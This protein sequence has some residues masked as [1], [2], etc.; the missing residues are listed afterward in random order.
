MLSGLLSNYATVSAQTLS[1]RATP[2]SGRYMVGGGNS[3]SA[4]VGET[5]NT[6]L[7][8]GFTMLT[9]GQQ[10]AELDLA[11]EAMSPNLCVGSSFAIA[12]KAIGFSNPA[13]TFTAQ[14]SN[15]S[16]SFTSPTAIGSIISAIS[17]SIQVTIPPLTPA[18]TGYFIRI[19]S[20]SPVFSSQPVSVSVN[21]LPAIGVVVSPSATVCPG[22]FVT[23]SGTGANTYTWSKAIVDGQP[24]APFSTATYT[25]TG[26]NGIG[27]SNTATQTVTVNPMPSID[28]AATPSTPVCAGTAVTLTATGASSYI[29]NGGVTNGVAFLPPS[30]ATYTVSGMDANGCSTD[31]TWV[32]IAARGDHSLGIKSDGTLW[33]WG[34]NNYGQLGDG[35]TINSNIPVQVGTATD[36]VGIAAGQLHSLGLKAD[37]TAWAWGINTSGELGTTSTAN[38]NT[39][40]LVSMLAGITAV[41]GGYSHSLFLKSD[42]TVWATGRNLEGQLGD[43]TIVSKRQPIQVSGLSNVAAIS[44]GASHSLFLQNNGTAWACGYNYYGSLG[45]NTNTNRAIPVPVTGISGIKSIAA[46]EYHSLFLGNNGTVWGTGYSFDGELGNGSA[47]NRYNP[48]QIP[49]FDHISAIAAG[50]LHSLFLKT[51]GTVWSTGFNKYGA[52]GLGNDFDRQSPAQVTGLT[53]AVSISGGGYHSHFLQGNGAL[54]SCGRNE[55]GQMGT[56]T[57][58]NSTTY[59]PVVNPLGLSILVT[60]TPSATWYLDADNDGHY[61]SSLQSCTSPG[62]GYNQTATASGDCDDAD[63]TKWQSANLYVDVDDDGYTV[64]PQVLLCFGADIPTG[65]S[66]M[67]LGED[68]DDNNSAITPSQIWY[69]DADNDGYYVSSLQSC[70]SPGAGYNQTATTQGDCDDADNTKWRAILR[71]LDADG[72]GYTVG[73]LTSVCYGATVPAIYRATSLGSDCDDQNAAIQAVGTWY[74]DADND[75][76]YISSQ[77][78]CGSPGAGYNQTATFEGDCDDA[79]NTQFQSASIYVDMDGDGFS[80]GPPVSICFGAG[81]PI[82]YSP[83]S[84]GEDCDDN[85]ASITTPLTWYLDV[86]NDGYYVSSVQSCTS[87]GVAYSQTAIGQGDCNDA[88]NTKWRTILRYL[89]ADGD[90]YTVGSLTSVCYGATIPPIYRANSLGAD[91]DDQNAA[92]QAVGTWYLDADNDGHYLSSQI[93]CGSPGAGYNQ[94]ATSQGDC[95][96]ADNTKWQ[97]ASFYVDADNDGF[98][99]GPAVLVCFGNGIPAG[100]SPMSFGDDCNDN[101]ASIQTPQMWF[102]DADNDGYFVSRVESCVNPGAGYNRTATLE[103]DCD[104]A[105]NTKWRTIIQYRDADGDGYTV[106]SPTQVCYGATI[107]A[108]YRATSLG[109]DCNDQD[110]AAHDIG[111]WYLDADNDGYYVSSQMSCGSPGTGYNQTATMLGDCDDADDTRWQAAYLY[112]DGDGDGY[113]V[114]PPVS[115]CIGADI[116]VGYSI[117]SNGEDCNDNN[118]EAQVEQTWY[119]DAD[120]DGHYISTQSACSMPALGYRQTGVMLGDCD[121][122]DPTVFETP[123]YYDADNDGHY[124]YTVMSCTSPGAGFNQTAITQGDCNDLDPA[125]FMPITW[126]LDADNDGYYIDSQISCEKPGPGYNQIASTLGDCDDNNAAVHACM[127][128]SYRSFITGNFSTPGTWEY[129]NGNSWQIASAPPAIGDDITIQGGHTITL[130][131]D[132]TVGNN[133]QLQ[134]G[135]SLIVNP[136]RTLS[137]TGTANFNGQPVIV[138]S[139]AAGTGSIGEGQ[140]N[141]SGAGNVTIERY[142]PN[143][144]RRWRLLTIPVTGPGI[145]QAW[146]EGRTPITSTGAAA[147]EP[148]VYGTIITGNYTASA[149]SP[150][151]GFDWWP[152]LGSTATASI[153]SYTQGAATG[154]WNGVP[155]MATNGSEGYLIFVRGDRK[156][157]SGSGATT[158]RATGALKTG[159]SVNIDATKSHTLVG[160]P[161]ASAIDFEKVAANSGNPTSVKADRFWVWDATVGGTGGY[162]LVHQIGAGQ[163]E[164][165]PDA[166]FGTG[167]ATAGSQYIQSSQ[168]FFVEPNTGGFV[169]IDD[170]D[171]AIVSGSAPDLLDAT[172]RGTFHTNLTYDNSGILTLADGVLSTFGAGGINTVG[173]DDVGKVDN[174]SESIAL[175]REGRRLALEARAGIGADDTLYLRLGNLT[176]RSYALQFK[177]GSLPEGLTAFLMDGWLG[178]QTVLPTG[179]GAISSY[180]FTVTSAAG[181]SAADRFK[182]VF[183]NPAVLPVVFINAKAYTKDGGTRVEWQVGNEEDIKAYEVEKSTDG[184]SFARIGTIPSTGS[185]S[186]SL[187]DAHSQLTTD[188][189]LYYRIKAIGFDGTMQYSAVLK[190]KTENTKLETFSVSPNPVKDGMMTLQLGNVKKRRYTLSVYNAIGQRVLAISVEHLGGSATQSI[191]LGS[192]LSAGVYKLSLGEGLEQSVVVE[193]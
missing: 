112:A 171:K 7:T 161:F 144:G 168:A 125:A 2:S 83:M 55:T 92:I 58:V 62:V 142:I 111:T 19:T 99:A 154:N 172:G 178:K 164:R 12:Y 36:W 96:D 71:Y 63:N 176:A 116:P 57:N 77:V 186:Y 103:G 93:S 42:G 157:T 159:A 127:A 102:L 61:I 115:F 140:A 84:F 30:T 15:A 52:L 41:A 31:K 23:L 160:N 69:L 110:A 51:D 76:H 169:T 135:A 134:A 65:Y 39:P 193:R 90:G 128:I 158:L 32:K 121:D 184:S 95:D 49:A 73:S 10:Q 152:A 29:W 5:F 1:P 8:S 151:L 48:V 79:D 37:G 162:R 54:N 87:P 86:D 53:N 155:T 122:S 138:K 47:A 74:L 50:S 21:T 16:G 26:I 192:R 67:S 146:A 85:N 170:D 80:V 60:V 113:T 150:A 75:G 82:G 3:L 97:S 70:T 25:V 174:F 131:V 66:P 181:S 114:G 153:R 33:A 34:I 78:S 123:W 187:T 28:A 141:I 6:T 14:L 173:S 104:D 137:V 124:L 133:L 119:L 27:C 118:S 185:K 20:N 166:V 89:D 59:V 98:S 147:S 17:G 91:C 182:I 126:Y 139:S 180:P 130:D 120:N 183:S 175:I 22:S 132:Y 101:D 18:G 189:S 46:G 117:V 163:W 24:F 43:N 109:P 44:A 106:G 167:P 11:M 4:T 149:P 100:Y 156:V 72:D 81:I 191:R 108:G 35:T 88:D 94:T 38:S 136:G 40:V 64:G 105:D 13:N 107:P 68:C 143:S 45:D 179:E 9:Q 190:L 148:G 56:G 177:A 188:N 129:N 145:R 165:V